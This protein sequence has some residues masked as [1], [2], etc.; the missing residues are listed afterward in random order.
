MLLSGVIDDTVCGQYPELI[1]DD[2]L[3]LLAMLQRQYDILNLSAA[4]KVLLLMCCEVRL[5][6][7]QVEQVVLLMLVCP[8]YRHALPK[9]HSAA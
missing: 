3:H 1:K 7:S 4:Q 9:D 6:F 2:L 8:V 5:L